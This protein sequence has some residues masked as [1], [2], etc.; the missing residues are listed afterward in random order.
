MA[1][2]YYQCILGLFILL[3]V[4]ACSKALK[5]DNYNYHQSFEELK[6]WFNVPPT[7]TSEI[8]P[9]SGVYSAYT[10]ELQPFSPTLSLRFNEI[11][12][13]KPKRVKVAVWYYSTDITNVGTLCFEIKNESGETKLWK[14]KSIAE[15]NAKPFI[16]TLVDFSV[17][18]TNE[19][20][21]PNNQIRVFF[22]N[23]GKGKIYVDD[24][25][26]EVIRGSY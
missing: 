17:S 11:E 21:S 4:G 5:Y 24:F 6:G 22:W 25:T 18:F 15:S 26:V 13:N 12:V 8:I 23:T 1:R 10:N 20:F 19:V 2:V 7:I 9:H 16:W 14:V 3:L